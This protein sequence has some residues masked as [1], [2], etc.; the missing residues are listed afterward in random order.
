MVKKTIKT[1]LIIF[2]MMF[3][4]LLQGQTIKLSGTDNS[5]GVSGTS[6]LHDWDMELKEFEATAQLTTNEEG[7]SFIEKAAFSGD[8]NNLSSDNSI[9]DNKAHDALDAEDHPEILFKQKGSAPMEVANGEQVTLK[10]TLSIAGEI[11]TVEVTVNYSLT[12][13]KQLTINGESELNMTDFG[14]KPPKAMFGTIKTDD[15]VNVKFKMNL[16]P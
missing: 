2:L 6:S 11:K 3:P 12:H 4:F 13:E 10:G 9:M 1:G 8:A 14:M 7:K 15:L 16:K 5:V